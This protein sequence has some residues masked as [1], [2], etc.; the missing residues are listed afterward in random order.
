MRVMPAPALLLT[1]AV[2]PVVPA[3]QVERYTLHGDEVAV[4]NLAGEL[5]VEPGQGAVT[6][7]VTRGGSG[8]G[9]LKV[10]HGELD[11]RDALRVVY[12]S[13]R[14]ISERLEHGSS[15]QLR[16]REDG[17]FGDVGEWERHHRDWHSEGR[18]VTIAGQGGGLDAH[19]DIVVQVPSGSRVSLYLA[20]GRVSITNVQGDLMVDAHDSPVSS[21]GTRGELAID[22]G[23]GAVQVSQ[24]DGDLSV[25]TGSG[26]V[27]LTRCKGR[28]LV[29]DTGSGDVTGTDLEAT[30]LNIDTGSGDVRLAGISAP[31]VSL[32]TGSGSV[33]ADLHADFSDLSVETGSGDITIKAPPSLGAELEIETSSGDI[34]TDFP[35]QVTRQS[36]D[37]LVG[38]V[39]D[40]KGTIAL[41]TGSG[42][43]KLLK[44]GS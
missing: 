34:E 40:G 38:R 36:R 20:V 14:I 43:I 8:A 1:L 18:R 42:G 26:R 27:E 33:S 7:Q 9:Q 28:H 30:D 32:E 25:D 31:R 39:G 5:W 10:A 19:A 15:T 11:G 3:Q 6:V 17:T 12:P 23:S 22:V 21:T 35:L 13:D 2:P 37:H 4:Y 16:V 41:E 44:G 29:V 24:A